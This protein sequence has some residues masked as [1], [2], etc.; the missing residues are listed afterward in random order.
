MSVEAGSQAKKK[1]AQLRQFLKKRLEKQHRQGSF[2]ERAQ[3]L[4]ESFHSWFHAMLGA[5]QELCSASEGEW[6]PK[7]LGVG[8]HFFFSKDEGSNAVTNDDSKTGDETQLAPRRRLPAAMQSISA[9]RLCAIGGALD[10]LQDAGLTEVPQLE[11]LFHRVAICALPKQVPQDDDNGLDEA[12]VWRA[13][14]WMAMRRQSPYQKRDGREAKL[15]GLPASRPG[16]RTKPPSWC[17][18]GRKLFE[19]AAIALARVARVN[20]E[21]AWQQNR[22]VGWAGNAVCSY[23]E[24]EWFDK[25]FGQKVQNVAGNKLTYSHEICFMQLSGEAVSGAFGPKPTFRPTPK[26]RSN[27]ESEAARK[28]RERREK[29]QKDRKIKSKKRE[30]DM[31]SR[32]S[33]RVTQAVVTVHLGAAGADAGEAAWGRLFE[34]HGLDGDGRAME[35]AEAAK[36]AGASTQFWEAASGKWVP[37]AIFADLDSAVLESVISSKR[38]SPADIL[39]GAGCDNGARDDWTY[40]FES[41]AAKTLCEDVLE[42]LRQQMEKADVMAGYMLT[43]SIASA[44]GGG[45]GAA[46]MQ[47][48]RYHFGSKM[49]LWSLSVTPPIENDNISS[50]EPVHGVLNAIR[51]M[52]SL[53][54]HVDMAVFFDLPTLRRFA[55]IP[56][57]L[58]KPQATDAECLGLIG[59]VLTTITSPL[60]LGRMIPATEGVRS[61]LPCDVR[62]NL[63]PYPS[64]HYA[65][66]S[67]AGA[68]HIDSSNMVAADPRETLT[69]CLGSGPRSRL[70]SANNPDLGCMDLALALYGRGCHQSTAWAAAMQYR[71]DSRVPLDYSRVFIGSHQDTTVSSSEALCLRNSGAIGELIGNWL[72]SYRSNDNKAGHDGNEDNNIINNNTNTPNE[73]I[74]ALRVLDDLSRSYKEASSVTQE[75]EGGEEEF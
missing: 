67:Y 74:E 4:T 42:S 38:Y 5:E 12:G 8:D 56:Q 64:L 28:S 9:S 46:F 73:D 52:P 16:T 72:R 58:A 6:E 71:K 34:E 44:M 22:L 47:E 24:L 33:G 7:S 37:R 69:R 21:S 59:T 62:Q 25:R 43:H 55:Q 50:N 11:E 35:S 70:H 68:F 61:A 14:K 53:S 20:W 57:G 66:P 60:R 54:D 36:V 18:G 65:L 40:C 19:P 29:V 26:P 23:P 1:I 30:I 27:I 39:A 15:L 3:A 10:V 51:S 63:C 45:F 48:S 75:A 17:F 13:L 49:P 32:T 2:D 41:K 31:R